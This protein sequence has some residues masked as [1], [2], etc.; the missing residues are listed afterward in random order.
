MKNQSISSGKLA[1]SRKSAPGERRAAG[2]Q[3][4][5]GGSCCIHPWRSWVM[6]R[7]GAARTKVRA[8]SYAA[9]CGAL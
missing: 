2:M 5:D 4:M 8:G 9:S 3:G 7:R 6:A 1:V